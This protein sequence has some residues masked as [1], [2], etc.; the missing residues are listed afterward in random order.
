MDVREAKKELRKQI[1]ERNA[2]LSPEYR[3]EASRKICEK[4]TALPE[5]RNAETVFCFVGVRFEPDTSGIIE[6][7]LADG[8]R[9]CV[10]LCTDDTTMVA[11]EIKDP[12]QDLV[13]SFYDLR[14]PR[15]G[16]PKVEKDEID[17]AVIPCVSCDHAGNRM[18]HGRGYYDRYLSGAEF[19]QAMICFEAITV[20]EGS[21]PTDQY[22]QPIERVITDAE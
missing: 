1:R 6:K 9:V 11:I 2:A 8:K 21:I 13:T 7:A 17:F 5:Y 14:E 10:P 18:G 12:E 22:D 20:P 19:E 16:L 15:E 3:A 4:I